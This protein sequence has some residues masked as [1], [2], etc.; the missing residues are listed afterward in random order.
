MSRLGGVF[1]FKYTHMFPGC[2]FSEYA[3]HKCMRRSYLRNALNAVFAATLVV[4]ACRPP[5]KQ[6]SALGKDLGHQFGRPIVVSAARHGELILVIPPART[7]TTRPDCVQGDTT[8]PATLARKV[9]EYAIAHYQNKSSL[10]S[11]RVIFDSGD[12][13]SAAAPA[14]YTWSAD[15]LAGKRRVAAGTAGQK[16]D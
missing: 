15:D 12:S 2:R 13:D 5:V 14:N 16:S 3:S 8:D 1:F 11:V 10:K 9:A 7:D 6:V 4:A